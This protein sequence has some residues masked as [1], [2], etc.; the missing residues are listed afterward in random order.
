MN[1]E[2]ATAEDAREAPVQEL[3]ESLILLGLVVS[4]VSGY[5]GIAVA[6]LRLF[7]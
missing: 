3:R 4:S 2:V 6:A 7:A 1:A 5:I